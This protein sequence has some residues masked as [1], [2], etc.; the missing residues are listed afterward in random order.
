VAKEFRFGVLISPPYAPKSEYPRSSA[1]ISKILGLLF[2]TL[3]ASEAAATKFPK[4]NN[5][6]KVNIFVNQNTLVNVF[7]ACDLCSIDFIANGA[8]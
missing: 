4:P 2:L 8:L 3:T 7:L 6:K 5:I 1:T